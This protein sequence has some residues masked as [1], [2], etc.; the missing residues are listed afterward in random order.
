VDAL[1]RRLPPSQRGPVLRSIRQ[2]VGR[3]APQASLLSLRNLMVPLQEG[4]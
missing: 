4:Q 3:Q 2:Q 1:L